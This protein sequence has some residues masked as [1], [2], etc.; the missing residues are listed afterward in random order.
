MLSKIDYKVDIGPIVDQVTQLEFKKKLDLNYTEGKL[1]NGPYKIKEE[2]VGTPLGNVLNSIENIGQARL[3]S[4]DSAESY[5]A[6][7]DPDDRIHLAITTNP[8]C[9]LIDL[10][11]NKMFH[12]P[13]DGQLWHMDTGTT[14]VAANFGA[15]SRIHLNIRVLLPF[16]KSPGF[17]FTV[18]GGDYDWKQESYMTLMSFF[19]KS[20]KNKIIFGFEKI[21]EREVLINCDYEILD[22]YI[23]KLKE[24]GFSVSI[25]PV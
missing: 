22:P 8:H 7:A 9:Y 13:V 5:T 10:D 12:L 21:S 6:H 24:K 3:L 16:F 18:N 20:I 19:N 17:K 1:L 25:T 2:F 15:R 11:N 14:H 23:Q 4:L